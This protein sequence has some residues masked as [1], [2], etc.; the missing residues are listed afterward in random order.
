MTI[1]QCVVY[2][3]VRGI[4]L[5]KHPFILFLYV[6]IHYTNSYRSTKRDAGQDRIEIER[7]LNAEKLFSSFI[8]FSVLFRKQVNCF[9]IKLSLYIRKQIYLYVVFFCYGK[10]DIYLFFVL[11][12]NFICMYVFPEIFSCQFDKTEIIM[13]YIT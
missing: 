1:I 11:A 10:V 4:L 3:C 5:L 13:S 8:I 12:F 7:N 6:L 9:Y 2:V